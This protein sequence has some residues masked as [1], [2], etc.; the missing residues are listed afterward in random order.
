MHTLLPPIPTFE[1]KPH[2]GEREGEAAAILVKL[3]YR[4]QCEKAQ[5]DKVGEKRTFQGGTR[6]QAATVL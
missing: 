6:R 2:E 4:Q 1:E 5:K 3:S